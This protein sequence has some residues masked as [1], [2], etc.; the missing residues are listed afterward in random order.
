VIAGTA[1]QLAEADLVWP[2]FKERAARSHTPAEELERHLQACRRGEA[3]CLTCPEGLVIVT[4]ELDRS[5]RIAC[6][7]L[8]AVSNGAFNA[9]AQYEEQ[10]VAIARD[11]EATELAFCTDRPA[12][13]H[14]LSPAWRKVGNCTFSRS[15]G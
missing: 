7:V 10:M 8:L 2:R 6:M 11:L 5:G 15:I 1:F 14:L 4:L 12:W 3:L 13:R 9:F